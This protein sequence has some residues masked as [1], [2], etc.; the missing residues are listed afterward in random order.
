MR[1]GGGLVFEGEGLRPSG[2]DVGEPSEQVV[3]LDAAGAEGGAEGAGAGRGVHRG[4]GLCHK[5]VHEPIVADIS[6]DHAGAGLGQV[7][8]SVRAPAKMLPVPL[9]GLDLLTQ[10]CDHC[11][12]GSGGGG[13]GRGEGDGRPNCS[14]LS[15]A[16]TAPALPA[17]SRRRVSATVTW[18]RVSLRA[19]AKSGALTSSSRAPEV[20]RSSNVSSVAGKC[21]R[22]WCRSRSM[23]QVRSQICVLRA[24]ATTLV[25]SAREL[26]PADGYRWQKPV[27]H[28]GQHVRITAV[29]LGPGHPV[30]F[31]TSR[32]LQRVNRGPLHS[33]PRPA[34]RPTGCGRSRSRSAPVHRQHPYPGAVRSARVVGPPP[35]ALRQP[36]LVSGLPPALLPA[37]ISTESAGRPTR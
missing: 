29:T 33:W 4:K 19:R 8:L 12:Q 20:A 17:M 16:R 30:P 25:A 23:R 13:I 24:P 1:P 11:D 6:E 31:S 37:A 32:C 7:D 15:A 3:V 9:Q 34:P 26:Y 2:Q 35:A 18:A 21:S 36:G 10:G 5:R 28:T 27:H 14:P 22:R